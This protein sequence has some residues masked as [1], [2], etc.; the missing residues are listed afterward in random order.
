MYDLPSRRVRR[1]HTLHPKS[2]ATDHH[3]LAQVRSSE[4]NALNLFNKHRKELRKT[5]CT[6]GV[7]KGVVMYPANVT[8]G[9]RVLTCH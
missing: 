7:V 9:T 1:G 2:R 8:T 3:A 4:V 6:L 5:E